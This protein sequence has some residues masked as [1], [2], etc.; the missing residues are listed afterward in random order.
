MFPVYEFSFFDCFLSLHLSLQTLLM[1]S[2]PFLSFSFTPRSSSIRPGQFGY[3]RV[4]FSLPLHRPNRQARHTVN[5]TVTPTPALAE[6]GDETEPPRNE[7]E[8]DE[9]HGEAVMSDVED[10]TEAPA[11]DELPTTTATTSANPQ[12]HV[13]R[14]SQRNREHGRTRVHSSH[15]FSRSSTAS[16]LPNRQR[17]DWHSVTAPPPPAPHLPRQN[18]PVASPPFSTSLHRSSSVHT[19]RD[20][21][22]GFSPQV[23]AMDNVYAAQHP[24]MPHPGVDSRRDEGRGAPQVYRCPGLEKEYRRCFSQV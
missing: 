18:S 21:R 3:G 11:E 8:E 13:A 6:D 1:S 14:P 2:P 9:E 10:P 22:P 20:P 4:P 17:F 23:P 5:G 19:Q 15:T 7:E 24:Q 16:F 12:R